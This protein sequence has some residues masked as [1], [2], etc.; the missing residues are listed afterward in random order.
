MLPDYWYFQQ[1]LL[2]MTI[3]ST[4]RL[5]FCSLSSRQGELAA[6]SR[7][8]LPPHYTG[9]YVYFTGTREKGLW[10][11]TAAWKPTIVCDLEVNQLLF[12]SWGILQR[13]TIGATA[14][15]AWKENLRDERVDANSHVDEDRMGV[16]HCV[17][18]W[19]A[20]FG[21]SHVSITGCVSRPWALPSSP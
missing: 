6:P 13:A 19:T 8:R 9:S 21:L 18:S 11:L 10:N 7:T 1:P 12:E 16:G 5:D 3:T 2:L 14:F 15:L 20:H 4:C 17:W